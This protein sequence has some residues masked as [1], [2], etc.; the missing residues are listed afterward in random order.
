MAAILKEVRC[1]R[2]QFRMGSIRGPFMSNLVH[3]GPV[4][5]EEIMK[6][7]QTNDIRKTTNS[8]WWQ[9][10]T[11]TLDQITAITCRLKDETRNRRASMSISSSKV[12]R[13]VFVPTCTYDW[14]PP[15]I[16]LVFMVQLW[17]LLKAAI[18]ITITQ[19]PEMDSGAVLSYMHRKFY[20]QYLCLLVVFIISINQSRAFL[21]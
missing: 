6:S 1:Y 20:F 21:F 4:V 15:S 2:M 9:K 14:F 3:I 12:S 13:Y 17:K 10:F 16:S 19:Y 7:Q 5:S 11:L 18:K 8:V